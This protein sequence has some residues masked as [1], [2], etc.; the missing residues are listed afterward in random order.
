M[1]RAA[2]TN[3]GRKPG[4]CALLYHVVPRHTAFGIFSENGR[5]ASRAA[6]AA[7]ARGM[8]PTVGSGQDQK[9]KCGMGRARALGSRGAREG[10][11][12][13]E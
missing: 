11:A 12:A 9:E 7:L 10:R 13:R 3:P 1:P 2:F 4:E 8:E 5:D 6:M